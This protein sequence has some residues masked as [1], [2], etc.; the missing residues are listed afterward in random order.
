MSSST[1]TTLDLSALDSVSGG[2]DRNTYVNGGGFVGK[3]AG[4]AGGAAAGAATV[5]GTG[6]GAAAV[7]GLAGAAGYD[8]GGWAGKKIGGALWD[9][10]S[11]IGDRVG[12]AIYG[13]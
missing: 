5:P 13:R 1:L 6:P 8:L 10:G 11:W 9:A 2:I 7:A 3:Y 4:A 12:T